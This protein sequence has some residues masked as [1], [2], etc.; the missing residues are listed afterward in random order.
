M[1]DTVST[2]GSEKRRNKL[3]SKQVVVPTVIVVAVLSVAGSYILGYSKG[4]TA[5][6]QASSKAL[7]DGI[8]NL[9]NPINALS[10]NPIAPY[11]IIGKADSIS[12]SKLTV[13]MVNGTSKTVVVTDK[14][15]ITKSGKTIKL[16]DIANNTNLTVFTQKQDANSS[17]KDSPNAS[18]I[19]VR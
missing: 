16:S 19:I 8:S 11:T 17:D 3:L 13:K 9:I 12:G 1:K 15:K 6:Q 18:R 14:T 5:G 10:N 7:R 2:Q 4:H